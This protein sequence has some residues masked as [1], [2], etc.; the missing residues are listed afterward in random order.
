MQQ[1]KRYVQTKE[2][3]FVFN[4]ATT[5]TDFIVV[6]VLKFQVNNTYGD[7]EVQLHSVLTLALDAQ[8]ALSLTKE[9]SVPIV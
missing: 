9:H 8:A 2:Q 7:V 5:N 4:P 6:P 1:F 3:T